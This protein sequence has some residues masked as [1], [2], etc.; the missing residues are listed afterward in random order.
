MSHLSSRF[1]LHLTEKLHFCGGLSK[2]ITIFVIVIRGLCIR[3]VWTFRFFTHKKSILWLPRRTQLNQTGDLFF[4]L[5]RFLAP[6]GTGTWCFLSPLSPLYP[7]A[8]FVWQQNI[9]PGDLYWQNFIS[10][11]F[12]NLIS[13]RP[14]AVWFHL[15][16]T[17]PQT[18]TEN[19]RGFLE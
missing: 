5:Y 12:S 14:I 17:S 1:G 19:V 8:T 9:S 3:K 10:S 18:W 4:T 16:P 15:I 7:W 2:D 6:V 13:I 11:L